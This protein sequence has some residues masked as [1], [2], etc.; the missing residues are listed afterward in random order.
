MHPRPPAPP[1]DPVPRAMLAAAALLLAPAAAAAPRTTQVH[2]S[3]PP[4]PQPTADQ[5]QTNQPR[6]RSVLAPGHGH[7]SDIDSSLPSTCLEVLYR[8]PSSLDG[9]YVLQ[10]SPADLP[11]D[12]Y[13]AGMN[14][15]D[16][17]ARA[18]KEF[19]TLPAVERLN[20]FEYLCGEECRE[21]NPGDSTVHTEFTK[22]RIN[23][24]TLFVDM[25][26]YTFATSRGRI[27]HVDSGTGDTTIF[28]QQP[29][30]TAG[31]C[32]GGS[33]SGP[34]GAGGAV[35]MGNVDVRGTPFG[36]WAR[37]LLRL[38]HVPF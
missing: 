7:G 5:R 22:V 35:G 6:G 3:Q 18:P 29:F 20:F 28:T 27:T 31:S 2:P 15:T 36:E 19:L 37:M 24:C 26:D 14:T 33:G 13:C 32:E 23:P 38:L 10:C 17:G 12:V 4:Q 11:F 21:L 34:G 8:D 9:E 25:M 30:G 1:R 16:H